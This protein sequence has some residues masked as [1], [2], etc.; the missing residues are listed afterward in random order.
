MSMLDDIDYSNPDSNEQRNAD[1][2]IRQSLWGN[3]CTK[4]FFLIAETME[5]LW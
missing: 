3:L 5:L 1:G 2:R 4:P